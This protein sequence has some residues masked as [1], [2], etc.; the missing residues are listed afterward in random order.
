MDNEWITEQA[1]KYGMT[2]Q[3]F[4]AFLAASGLI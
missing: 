1:E 3:Q 4:L 2:E